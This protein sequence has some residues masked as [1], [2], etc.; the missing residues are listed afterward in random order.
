[1][2]GLMSFYIFSDLYLKKQKLKKRRGS[3]H[4]VKTPNR[5]VSGIDSLRNN[6]VPEVTRKRVLKI[7]FTGGP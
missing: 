6:N 3:Y 1:M 5:K 4:E 2:M 7:V